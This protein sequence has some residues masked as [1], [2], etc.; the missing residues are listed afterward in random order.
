MIPRVHFDPGK[1]T[2]YMADKTTVR[3]LF[4]LAATFNMHNE[5]IDIK[6]T[7]LHEKADHSGSHAV[8]VRQHPRFDGSFKHPHA[9]GKLNKDIYGTP[10]AGQTYLS[11]VVK[12]LHEHKSF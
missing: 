6:A 7:Y 11:T 5:H 2:T 1:T 10:G 8:N 12:L 3:L 9:V 4:A